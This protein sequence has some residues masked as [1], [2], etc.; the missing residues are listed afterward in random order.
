VPSENIVKGRFRGKSCTE[1]LDCVSPGSVVAG[2]CGRHNKA[3]G[4][5]NSS[6]TLSELDIFEAHIASC[7]I[8]KKTPQFSVY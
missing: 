2:S 7:I 8:K 4:F 5:Q 3:P 1:I 6:Q